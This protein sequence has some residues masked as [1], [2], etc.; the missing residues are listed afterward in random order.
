MIHYCVSAV[1]PAS[2]PHQ[3]M[4][5]AQWRLIQLLPRLKVWSR[6]IWGGC[7][8]DSGYASRSGHPNKSGCIVMMQLAAKELWISY[9]W[10]HL[11][12]I[13]WR[14]S[15]VINLL[16]EVFMYAFDSWLRSR[17]KTLGLVRGKSG[18]INCGTW[19]PPSRRTRSVMKEFIFFVT[20]SPSGQLH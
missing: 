19:R 13:I 17:W 10:L 5:S 20:N 4:K 6:S 2:K 7:D 16:C 9:R 18:A 1:T 8:A 14:C 3:H 11:T 15:I 12:W